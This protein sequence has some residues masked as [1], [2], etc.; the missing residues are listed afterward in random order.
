LLSLKDPYSL[1]GRIIN[2]R[3]LIESLIAVGG[4]SAVYSARQIGVERRVAFKI[5]L[6]HL[7][8]QNQN[9]HS[10]FEREARTAGRLAH[11]NI[12]TVHDAGL[13]QDGISYIA[14]EWLGRPN[15]GE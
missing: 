7:A 5:L 4:M 1:M 14:M 8:L 10:L 13:T 6:P 12:A 3:Y 11:E 15:A 9:M 2:D